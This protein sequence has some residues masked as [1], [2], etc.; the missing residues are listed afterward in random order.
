M[1]LVNVLNFVKRPFVGEQTTARDAYLGY[2]SYA[3]AGMN[4]NGGQTVRRTIAPMQPAGIVPG[5]TLKLN[6]PTATGN[7]ARNVVVQPLSEMDG[8]VAQGPQF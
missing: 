7:V 2:Q 1:K 5:N 8:P 3:F 4:G 6:D